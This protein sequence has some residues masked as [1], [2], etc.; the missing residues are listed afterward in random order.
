MLFNNNASPQIAYM[1]STGKEGQEDFYIEARSVGGEVKTE[2]EE[3]VIA[4]SEKNYEIFQR[5]NKEYISP[6]EILADCYV[7]NGKTYVHFYGTA[8]EKGTSQQIKVDETVVFD[9]AFTNNIV[10]YSQA[11]RDALKKRK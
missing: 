1:L 9:F 8:T 2:D 4:F 7:E 6:T 3:N 5:M 10:Q 11:D